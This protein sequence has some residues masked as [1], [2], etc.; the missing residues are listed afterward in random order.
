MKCRTV[1]L[2]GGKGRAIVCGPRPKAR[3]C[4]TCYDRTGRYERS[5]KLCDF[6]DPTRPSG[7]CDA[8][9]CDAHATRVGPDRD[10]CPKHRQEGLPL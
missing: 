3:P 9:M 2:P 6:P 8:P 1:V 5:T 7:T 10:Y 4:K